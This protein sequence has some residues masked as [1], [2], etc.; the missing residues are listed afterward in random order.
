MGIW[1]GQRTE[2]SL[3]LGT[4]IPIDMESINSSLLLLQQYLQA[5]FSLLQLLSRNCQVFFFAIY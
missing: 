3:Q 5:K 4:R 2:V 1:L